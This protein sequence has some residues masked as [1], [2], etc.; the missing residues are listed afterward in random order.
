MMKTACYMLSMDK[1][2]V[3][4]LIAL[5]SC[6][7]S[8]FLALTL[9]HCIPDVIPLPVPPNIVTLDKKVE[10]NIETC[11]SDENTIASTIR[12][13]I[14]TSVDVGVYDT[15]QLNCHVVQRCRYC[16]CA[17]CVGIAAAPPNLHRVRRWV[18]QQHR[19]H[20]KRSPG[21]NTQR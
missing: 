14:V 19:D 11:D 1:S 6:C 21:I 5:I 10:C 18:G 3:K 15:L 2:K 4:P 17:N 16:P 12:R 7:P 9:V 8:V 13:T 20:G